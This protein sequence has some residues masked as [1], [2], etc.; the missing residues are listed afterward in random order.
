MSR[1]L[2]AV[3][4]CALFGVCLGSCGGAGRETHSAVSSSSAQSYLSNDGDVLGDDREGRSD[5]YLVRGYGR[6]AGETETK[7]LE[8]LLMRYYMA[9]AAENGATACELLDPRLRKGLNLVKAMPHEDVP[10][11]GSTIFGGKDCAQVASLLFKLNHRQILE[12]SETFVVRDVRID[13]PGGLVLLG[14]RAMPERMM[15]VE[16]EQGAW[17]TGALLDLEVP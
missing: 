8:G 5:D 2:L 13:G 11:S 4:A 10:P 16:R 7:A 6:A 14:F 1:P 15:P 17:K 9:A 12:K 3:L